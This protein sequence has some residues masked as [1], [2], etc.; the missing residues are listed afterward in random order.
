[1]LRT[2][3]LAA[4]LP[5]TSTETFIVLP[6]DIRARQG[7]DILSGQVRKVT[8]AGLA[9]TELF[10]DTPVALLLMQDKAGIEKLGNTQGA[11]LQK[12]F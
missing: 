4:Q 5:A 9:V 6:D 12:M 3:R 11:V 8:T 1:M 7:V 2:A 10:G